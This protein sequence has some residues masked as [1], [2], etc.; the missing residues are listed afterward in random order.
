MTRVG[1]SAVVISPPSHEH[2]SGFVCRLVMAS[3]VAVTGMPRAKKR[4]GLGWLKDA[5]S[6]NHRPRAV[7]DPVAVRSDESARVLW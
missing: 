3:F 2:M 4:R 6:G 5:E 1:C 7:L